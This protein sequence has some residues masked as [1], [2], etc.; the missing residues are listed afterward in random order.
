[1]DN[2]WETEIG[3]IIR[4]SISELENVKNI[5]Q[6]KVKLRLAKAHNIRD[7]L[8]PKL[9]FVLKM[10]NKISNSGSGIPIH[11]QPYITDS[12]FEYEL[13]MP[14]LSEVNMMN[15]RFTMEFDDEDNVILHAFK[16]FSE[17]K[18][19]LVGSTGNDYTKFIENSIK[20]FIITWYKRKTGDELYKE[21]E[22]MLTINTTTY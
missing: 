5:Q 15:L 22:V 19:E 9:K 12:E 16:V 20:Y 14:D 18:T 10:I 21:Q 17:G 7:L 11:N 8:Y 4:D 2:N 1:M 13:N 3:K 6:E